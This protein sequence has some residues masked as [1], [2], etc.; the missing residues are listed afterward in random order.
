MKSR[1]LRT[2]AAATAAGLTLSLL[3][4]AP[5][6]AAT[7]A[8]RADRA[9]DWEVTQLADARINNVAY[10]FTDWGLTVDTYF[11]LVG[12][13]N[14]RKS[15]RK[16]LR[17]VSEHVREYV[18][19]RGDFYAG[20]L[21]KTLLA[22]RVGGLPA[23][24]EQANLNLRRKLMSLIAGNGRVQ[25]SGD[26]DYSNTI[27]QSLAV[28]GLARSGELPRLTARFLLRQQ[29][30][31]GY[32]RLEMS[33]AGCDSDGGSAD[34]DATG[35]ALQALRIARRE[36]GDVVPAG[37][38]SDAG[39]WLA[40][41]QKSNGAFN[42]SGPT[43]GAN[44]NSTGLA[45]QALSAV[46][47]NGAARQAADWIA[48]QQLTRSD[49]AGSPARKDLG[50]IAYNRADYEAALSDGITRN[51]RDVWRRS[52]PQAIS[53]LDREPLSTLSAP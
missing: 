12:A 27:T 42:G 26:T 4:A 17:T 18:S 40:S 2:A 11:G 47:R 41:E 33:A 25:D 19:Y 29:C 46:D 44:T 1:S 45:A 10:G 52:T 22:R 23:G 31:A 35:Y 14:H 39:A 16:V 9:A 7:N 15:A 53:G 8:D 21:A 43:A 30:E 34:V 36:R 51:K 37:A 13:D 32:F 38:I 20:A 48:R 28:L 5:A 49:T 6:M 3:P 50:A 24:V